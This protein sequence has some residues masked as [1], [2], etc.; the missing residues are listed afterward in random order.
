[1]LARIVENWLTNTG[2]LGYQAAFSQ[3]LTNEGY[4]ILHGPVHHPYEHGKDLVAFSPEGNLH[5]FQLKGG[6]ISLSEMDKLQGQ[7]FTLAGTAVT[8]PGVDPPRAPDRA[9]LVTN[10]RLS[11]PA[12]DRIR[13]FNDA[14]RERNFTIVEVIE[15]EQLL[16]RLLAAHGD[17]IPQELEDLHGLLR[18]VLAD[19]TGPF[20]VGEFSEMLWRIIGP[21]QGKRR[22]DAARA[23]ASAPLICSYASGAWQQRQNHLAVAE[24]WLVVAFAILRC[25]ELEDLPDELWKGSFEIARDS[26]RRSLAALIAEAAEAQD[27]VIPDL[28]DGLVYPARSLAVCG[29]AAAFLLSERDL[30][31]TPP[32][33][34]QIA[35]LLKRELPYVKAPGEAG[36]A[37]FLL[38]A[39]ALEVLGDIAEAAKLVT[40]WARVLSE[41]NASGAEGGI[42]DPYHPFSEV[43]LHSVGGETRLLEEHFHGEA[44]TL[45][46]AIDWLVRRDG[47]PLVERLWPAVTR[48]HFCETRVSTPANLL[49]HNDEEARHFS[50]APAAPASWAQL[51][52]EAGTVREAAIP[53][54]LWQ[55]QEMLPYLPLLYPYRLTSD[56]A[57]ALDY[58]SCNRCEVEFIQE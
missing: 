43:L 33:T 26:A 16:Q 18:L 23:V 13:S 58:M 9:F 52:E 45:H 20:P 7:L 10:G 41:S 34:D 36:M 17:F 49:G 31:E 24:A 19:G 47:R 37:Y 21:R 2:E 56:V 27:L 46:I 8:Y 42:P 39:L 57:K 35:S 25:A 15:I 50:W 30:A 51:R 53:S 28:V 11:P 22:T 44:Y 5:A 4:R 29:Y 54:R 40:T 55:N 12:R 6:D 1:M 38:L 32:P 48:I 3:L 14:N